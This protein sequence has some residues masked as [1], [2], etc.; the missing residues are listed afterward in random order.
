MK[1]LQV[2]SLTRSALK[3]ALE[4]NLYWKNDSKFV[5]FSKSKALW[6]LRNERIEDDDVCAVLGLEHNTLVAFIYLIPDW[7]NT[8]EGIHK[9]YWSSRWWVSDDYKTSILSTYLRKVSLESVQNQM[10]IKY[11]VNETE[12][13]YK[14]QP[15]TRFSSRERYIMLFD[16][17]H[18]FIVS[19]VKP[20]R[21]ALPLLKVFTKI[22]HAF[23][24]VINK[25]RINSKDISY[26]YL[27]QI[28]SNAW[29]FIKKHC[30]SDLI[31]KTKTYINWQ[32]DNNQYV[33]AKDE[34]KF[35][36]NCLISSISSNIYNLNFLISKT[37]KKIGFISA[38]VRRNEFVL[39]Y[40]LSDEEN[41]NTCMD[42]LVDNFIKSKCSILI[43][44][45]EILGKK[46]ASKFLNIYS[47]KRKI[48]SLAHH[49]VA[50]NFENKDVHQQDGNFA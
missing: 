50:L 16:L 31:K 41:H 23:I 19:K 25:R 4:Q 3:N 21:I 10:I 26:E 18:N 38:L 2:I 8:K 12:E 22:S 43:V 6:L 24:S 48:Y 39:R 32:I 20:L 42:A 7:I 44:E 34:H 47:N 33:I 40:F 49:D 46:I 9:I 13:Y 37:T 14:K 35:S 11:L 29:N 28:D 36:Q 45:D 15:F 27:S 30:D 17:N 5:P 1:D